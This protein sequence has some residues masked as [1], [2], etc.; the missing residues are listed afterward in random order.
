M[1]MTETYAATVAAVTPVYILL[2]AV[3]IKFSEQQLRGYAQSLSQPL[4]DAAAIL[5]H[6]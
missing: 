4:V 1:Q 2:G 3:E 5:D 6:R